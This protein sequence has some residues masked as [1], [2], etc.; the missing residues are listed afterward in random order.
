MLGFFTK[1]AVPQGAEVARMV[2]QRETWMFQESSGFR[3]QGAE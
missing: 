2:E 1:L 3:M